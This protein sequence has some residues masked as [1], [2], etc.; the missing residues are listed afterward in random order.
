[1]SN[2]QEAAPMREDVTQEQRAAFA[3]VVEGDSDNPLRVAKAN[4]VWNGQHDN[5][6]LVHTARPNAG[7]AEVERVA[8]AI[9]TADLVTPDDLDE[10]WNHLARAALTAMREGADQ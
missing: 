2:E 10:Y 3:R 1:M 7:D 4:A 5:E 9:S 6:V 8:Q